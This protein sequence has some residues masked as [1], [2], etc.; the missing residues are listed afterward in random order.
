MIGVCL[1]IM[2]LV[3]FDCVVS[4]IITSERCVNNTR[5]G[6]RSTRS[7]SRIVSVWCWMLIEMIMMM[8]MIEM[9]MVFVT[10]CV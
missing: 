4:P 7:N 5:E 8:M 3:T 6:V 2:V 10:V 9:M 1:M